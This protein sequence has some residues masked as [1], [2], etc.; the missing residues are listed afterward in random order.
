MHETNENTMSVIEFIL[1]YGFMNG[2][3]FEG[4]KKE[5]APVRYEP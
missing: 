3:R 4:L 1:Q 2:Y 5:S